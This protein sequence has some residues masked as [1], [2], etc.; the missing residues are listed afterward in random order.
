[1]HTNFNHFAK[2]V[3]SKLLCF[4]IICL[5]TIT[6]CDQQSGSKMVEP[7][8]TLAQEISSSAYVNIALHDIET[9]VLNHL[10][11]I[12]N[13]DLNGAPKSESHLTGL[14]DFQGIGSCA[15]INLDTDLNT[16]TLDFGDGCE[17]QYGT[18]RSGQLSIEYESSGNPVGNNIKIRTT[19]FRLAGIEITGEFNW[20][21]TSEEPTQYLESY[22]NQIAEM[23]IS[24]ND[25]NL[26]ITGN[27]SF[28]YTQNIQGN[29]DSPNSAFLSIENN[30]SGTINESTLQ[31]RGNSTD[32]S[33][34][35]WLN[36]AIFPSIGNENLTVNNREFELT[37]SAC[38]YSFEV[39][40]EDGNNF[41]IDLRN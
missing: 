20:E 37:F 14:N 3:Y 28:V 30:I 40:D 21:K 36:A 6:A 17:D 22:I 15:G 27:R 8:L 2:S 32:Y 11:F 1:M 39:R 24:V 13:N 29:H 7:S 34:S 19:N 35:C 12:E 5:F 18:L 23:R 31:L 38:N 26:V 41:E 4:I 25:N 10:F 33:A 16:L 9:I